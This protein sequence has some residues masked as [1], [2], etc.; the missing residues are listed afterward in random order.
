MD[1]LDETVEILG[2]DLQGLTGL[3]RRQLLIRGSTYRFVLLVKV[4]DISI[5]NLDK[6]LDRRGR[7]HARVCNAKGA[8]Q[9][10]QDALAVTVE[11]V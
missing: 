8:L 10:F 4:V 9:A 11:L 3:A 1:E 2:R 6:Q 5:E 7:L